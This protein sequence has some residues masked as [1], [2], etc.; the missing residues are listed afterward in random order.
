MLDVSGLNIDQQSEY[1]CRVFI[2][3]FMLAYL[4]IYLLI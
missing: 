4:H 1:I 3:L 2:Y